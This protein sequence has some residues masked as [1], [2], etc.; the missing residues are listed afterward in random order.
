MPL[1]IHIRV[2]IY[3]M[4]VVYKIHAKGDLRVEHVDVNIRVCD[5]FVRV[6]PSWL[7]RTI[8]FLFFW[9]GK[10]ECMRRTTVVVVRWAEWGWV[11][12]FSVCIAH[13]S[14]MSCWRLPILHRFMH[15]RTAFCVP[16]FE[17][18]QSNS[19]YTFVLS[20]GC[21]CCFKILKLLLLDVTEYIVETYCWR[22]Y[23]RTHLTT[24][25]C[26]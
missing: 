5:C 18:E 13:C 25:V 1:F 15:T 12:V 16:I 9:S 21:G 20:D 11:A 6:R 8:F 22:I 17:R 14:D 7:G 24:C 2:T 23:V 26:V 19:V 4:M 10:D 3:Y